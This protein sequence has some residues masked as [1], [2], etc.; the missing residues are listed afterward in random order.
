VLCAQQPPH[1]ACPHCAAPLL[2]PAAR[3]A[4]IAQLEELRA[5]TLAEE[6]ERRREEDALRLA[7]GA[8]PALG[9][10]QHTPQQPLHG[11]APGGG[12]AAR[13]RGE[14]GAGAGHR[15]LSTDPRTN[16]VMVKSFVRSSRRAGHGE[17]E[18][19]EQEGA[20]PEEGDSEASLSRV[21]PPPREVEYVRVQR[22]PATRW[23]DLKGGAAGG[24][25]AKYV[26]PLL[27]P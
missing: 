25:T 13:G 14:G 3:D 1:R 8:F 9:G 24:G 15:V 7:E 6:E 2:T 23:V 20:A 19:M 11:A 10:P 4:L 18:L 26:A 21:L 12:S 17:D 5:R 27:G 22:G 16:R